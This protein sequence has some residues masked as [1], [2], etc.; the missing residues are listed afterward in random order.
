MAGMVSGSGSLLPSASKE[1]QSNKLIQ[2]LNSIVSP[3][4]RQAGVDPLNLYGGNT[5]PLPEVP[6][7]PVVEPPP[8]MPIAD[9][10]AA[11]TAR[12]RSI[13]AQTARRGRASTI[14]SDSS[15]KLGS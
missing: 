12:R 13:A 15:E 4:V 7:P 3:K 1:L 5:P 11:Q 10:G 14:L 2:P 9:A 8:V 6:A